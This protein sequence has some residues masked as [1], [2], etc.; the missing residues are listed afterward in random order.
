MNPMDMP[1][2]WLFTDLPGY[3]DHPDQ[4]ATYSSFEWDKL[5][6]IQ[7]VLDD[8]FKW[9]LSK[10]RV[11]NSSQRAARRHQ[12]RLNPVHQVIFLVGLGDVIVGTGYQAQQDVVRPPMVVS[13]MTGMEA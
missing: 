10:H 5:P 2:I 13:K 8:E 6:P 9:L 1:R 12:Q 11:P 3:R 7:A 4:Y